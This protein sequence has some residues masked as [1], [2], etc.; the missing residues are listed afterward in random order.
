V[1]RPA[2]RVRHPRRPGWACPRRRA[3]APRTRWCRTATG[4][5]MRTGALRC[6]ALRWRGA[7]LCPGCHTGCAFASCLG[8]RLRRVRW[9]LP[10]AVRAERLQLWRPAGNLGAPDAL[11]VLP[12]QPA[13]AA[14]D[15]CAPAVLLARVWAAGHVGG[16]GRDGDVLRGARR[17]PQRRHRQLLPGDLGALRRRPV[18][19]Q[20]AA[21]VPGRLPSGVAGGA[22][23]GEPDS[24]GARRRAYAHARVVRRS[25]VG[26]E[27]PEG[28][29]TT[30][31]AFACGPPQC[32]EACP[33]CAGQPDV[34]SERASGAAREGKRAAGA[35]QGL[36]G[37]ERAGQ[38]TR[39][40]F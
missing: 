32:P 30:A 25:R 8:V 1:R 13:G 2:R 15:R 11:Q 27:K 10:P 7:A 23:S 20:H 33:A 19:R 38:A 3:W 17:Q 9:S 18:P 35:G 4:V 37:L 5:P 14:R 24:R 39:A 12:Q 16:V 22:L 28:P 29:A 31:R 34:Q 36:R 21:V 6:G 26:L 40:G